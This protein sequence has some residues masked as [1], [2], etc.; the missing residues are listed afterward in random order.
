MKDLVILATLILLTQAVI[1]EDLMSKV[2]VSM[3]SHR[4]MATNLRELSTRA[5]STRLTL[6]ENYTTYL[7]SPPAVLITKIQSHCG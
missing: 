5:I 1:R 6:H 3:P 7:L 2:P 4:D